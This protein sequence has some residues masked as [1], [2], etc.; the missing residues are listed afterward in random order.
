MQQLSPKLNYG[1]CL[2]LLLSH[3]DNDTLVKCVFRTV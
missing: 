3:Y 1:M 2:C